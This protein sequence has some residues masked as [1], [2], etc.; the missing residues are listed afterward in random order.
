MAKSKENGEAADTLEHEVHAGGEIHQL[1]G[2]SRSRCSGTGARRVCIEPFS[3][4][5]PA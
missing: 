2:S 3:S 1:G 4:L 5:A